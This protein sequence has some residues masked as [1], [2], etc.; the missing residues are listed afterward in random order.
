[1]F[2]KAG[3]TWTGANAIISVNSSGSSGNPIVFDRYGSGDD[4]I[5]NNS[6]ATTTWTLHSGSIWKKSGLFT[7]TFTVGVGSSGALGRSDAANTALRAG[8]FRNESGTI[9]IRLFDSSNPNSSTIYVPTANLN[10]TT[11]FAGLIKGVSGKG[12]WLEFNNLQSWYANGYGFEINGV[13]NRVNDCTVLGSGRDGILTQLGGSNFR[14]YRTEVSWS[15]A[16]GGGYG[17]GITFNTSDNWAINCNVHDNYLEGIDFLD[18]STS[19]GSNATQ[20]GAIYN[21]VTDNARTQNGSSGH[22]IYVDGA[23]YIFI[24]GNVISGNGITTG[25]TSDGGGILVGSE[26]AANVCSNI[27]IINNFIFNTR[28]YG[29]NFYNNAH[30]DTMHDIYVINNTVIGNQANT[31][32]RNTDTFTPTD[33]TNTANTL[34]S[35]NNIFYVGGNTSSRVCNTADGIGVASATLDADNN[36]YYRAS[37]QRLWDTNFG[38]PVYSL[39]GTGGYNSWR[40]ATGE[41]LNSI[42]SDPKLITVSDSAPDVHLWQTASGQ[43][44]NS[45]AFDN[46]MNSA[47]T[48]PSFLVSAG[49]LADGGA[50]VGSTRTDGVSDTGTMDMGYHYYNPTPTGSLTATNIQPATLYL[51]TTNTVN[52]DF[53]TAN[54]LPIDGKI[55]ATFPTSLGGGFTFNSGGTSAATF[56]SGGSG[57]IAVSI[58]GSVVTLT[59]S[60]GS[61]ISAGQ[62]VSIALT[63]VQNPPETGLTGAYQ[64]KT[65][66]SADTTID[67]DTNVSPDQIITPPPS[68]I[69]TPISGASL[70][71]VSVSKRN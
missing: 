48:P 54:A 23:D 4:P 56:N 57:S 26:H 13:G 42:Q 27:Y 39:A 15:V 16:N 3:D 47:F 69:T 45:P 8:E 34:V 37:D 25:T 68:F 64:L 59:R 11:N 32:N 70:S 36:C 35:R 65:T 53:T 7:N 10:G 30:E 5:F 41:D 22:G 61:A 63:F 1:M 43:A 38:N 18:W 28:R 31:L 20:S 24:Y 66:T 21:T 60:G 49:V 55:V 52:I 44:S 6:T 14:A 58:V 62:A 2:F 33:F 9:Y 12:A 71:G 50:V 40:A 67:I 17:Q 51:G 29:I 19:G 46:G